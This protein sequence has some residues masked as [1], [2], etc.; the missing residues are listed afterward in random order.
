MLAGRMKT[1]AGIGN[2]IGSIFGFGNKD[3]KLQREIENHQRHIENLQIACENLKQSMD[4]AWDI[5]NLEKFKN[6]SIANLK[7]QNAALQASIAAERDKK[8]SNDGQIR[9]WENQIQENNK[10]IKA[11]EEEFLESLGCFGSESNYKT[12]AQAFADAW[13]AFNQG[14]NTLQALQEQLDD[15]FD[16]MLKKQISLRVGDM[17]I[18]NL[19]KPLETALI[20]KDGTSANLDSIGEA[21][22]KIR[23]DA[24]ETLEL[25][26]ETMK[27]I[28]E[29][30]QDGA[31]CKHQPVETST[32]NTRNYRADGKCFGGP[33]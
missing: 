12:A 33:A 29:Q 14:S 32:R 19:L 15:L 17:I 25:F 8:N 26:N 30:L 20:N 5:A 6:E 1:L 23:E 11:L 3:K 22:E 13:V 28:A 4:D 27:Q 7:A 9:Q 16:T 21:L 2:T 18:G 31:R 24:P 10:V